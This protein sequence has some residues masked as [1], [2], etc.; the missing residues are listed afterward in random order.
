MKRHG[1]RSVRLRLLFCAL[2][3]LCIASPARADEAGQSPGEVAFLNDLNALTRSS[4][5]QT[6][7]AAGLAAEAFVRDRL[8]ALG[9]TQLFELS[10]PVW[11]LHTRACSLEVDGI[12][13]PLLAVRPNVIVPPVTPEGGLEAAL[14]YA[15]RGESA[16]FDTRSP[17]GKI[18]V[19]EY[20]S[21]ANWE[22]AFSLGARAVIFLGS[23][24]ETETAPKYLD[25]PIN[26]VRLYADPELLGTLDL[27]RDYP[28]VRLTSEVEWRQRVGRNVVARIAGTDTHFP[29]QRAEAEAL[30][31][32][33]RLDSYGVVPERA[34]SARRA[35]NVAALLEAAAR[36]VKYP[37]KRDLVLVFSD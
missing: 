3:A 26:L 23:G 5:R 6:G 35:G 28:Q 16:D 25:L 34:P 10:T 17:E 32:S 19:L 24:T 12:S 4:H 14:M 11:E 27:R 21:A 31:L 2:F 8:R 9:V 30:V 36:L 37:P 33:A 18:V 29:K 1:A 20:E 15:G 22:R 7:S 13:V